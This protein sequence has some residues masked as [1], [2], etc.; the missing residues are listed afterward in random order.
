MPDQ[1]MTPSKARALIELR[2]QNKARS[3]VNLLEAALGIGVPPSY[4]ELNRD[5]GR[6]ERQYLMPSGRPSPDF[7]RE[8]AANDARLLP[9]EPMGPPSLD[10]LKGREEQERKARMATLPPEEAMDTGF[11]TPQGL[12]IGGEDLSGAMLGD[13]LP[14]AV[15][16]GEKPMPEI[17][18]KGPDYEKK[19]R[20]A[21]FLRSLKEGASEFR[22]V[23]GAS[24]VFMKKGVPP[25]RSRRDEDGRAEE[26]RLQAKIDER[27][28]G[29]FNNPNSEASIFARDLLKKSGIEVPDSMTAAQAKALHPQIKMILD[30]WTRKAGIQ[31][32][33]DEAEA[34]AA[35]KR[36][37]YAAVAQGD[38]SKL[39]ADAKKDLLDY[40]KSFYTNSRINELK[41]QVDAAKSIRSRIDASE[42][43]GPNS[44]F[45]SLARAAGERGVMTEKDIADFAQRMGLKG[46]Y[47]KVYKF[48]GSELPPVLKE[49][50]FKV[51]DAFAQDARNSLK[52]EAESRINDLTSLHPG[53]PREAVERFFI[54]PSSSTEEPEAE[55]APTVQVRGS[56]GQTYTVKST[57]KVGDTFTTPEGESISVAEVYQ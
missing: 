27:E 28:Y 39:P 7:L 11:K 1:Y 14:L 50:I 22:N 57:A 40:K 54:G 6:M 43:F 52:A 56:D 12:R 55:S 25:D 29:D 32:K 21:Q 4:T 46:L 24:E 9:I 33:R 10:M 41:G 36:G 31:Q 44:A 5:T 13:D 42:S 2:R 15:Q 23:T 34:D 20:Q 48:F 38:L 47:D 19:L 17:K 37:D 26:A 53:L 45:R 18:P 49:E 8:K 51:A 30:D 35:A 16:A 3:G